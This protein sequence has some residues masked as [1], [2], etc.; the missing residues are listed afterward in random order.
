MSLSTR[1]SMA[2]NAANG[3][4][5]MG[6]WESDTAIVPKIPGNAGEGKGVYAIRPCPR[7]TYT[8]HRDR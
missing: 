6:T 7:D 4:S 8:I 1:G 3:G 2:D 5:Q